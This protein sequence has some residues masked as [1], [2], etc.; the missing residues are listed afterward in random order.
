VAIARTRAI[1]GIAEKAL[2]A[3][4]ITGPKA[5]VAAMSE[6]LKMF[7]V[8]MRND[9]TRTFA[10]S[11]SLNAQTR[12]ENLEAINDLVST[13]EDI[14]RILRSYDSSDLPR[15]DGLA[16]PDDVKARVLRFRWFVSS[17]SDCQR[18]E[19]KRDDTASVLIQIRED[20][21]MYTSEGIVKQHLDAERVS[22]DLKDL[23]TKIVL[24]L[25]EIQVSPSTHSMVFYTQAVVPPAGDGLKHGGCS[26]RHPSPSGA[27]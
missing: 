17:R 13:F 20:W 6:G 3:C 4:P 23:N 9:L 16:I 21:E 27:V 24:A 18:R 11:R 19:L 8:R 10:D 26:H 15:A 5:A 1:L 22:A 12:S 14:T 2:D 7:Q 25:S